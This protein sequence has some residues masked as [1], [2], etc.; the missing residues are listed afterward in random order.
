MNVEEKRRIIRS[1]EIKDKILIFLKRMHDGEIKYDSGTT[2]IWATWF[3]SKKDVQF[4]N[5][6]VNVLPKGIKER[7]SS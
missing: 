3:D 1:K 4:K 7:T 2:W 5:S 6:V